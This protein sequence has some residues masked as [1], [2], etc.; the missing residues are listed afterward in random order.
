M[1]GE[2]ATILQNISLS[3]CD[4]D[5]V[6]TSVEVNRKGDLCALNGYFFFLLINRLK[7]LS[8]INFY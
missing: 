2:V 1:E 7:K 5:P 4:K 6:L 8:F 3:Y